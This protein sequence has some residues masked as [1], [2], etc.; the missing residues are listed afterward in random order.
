[1]CGSRNASR[2]ID[3]KSWRLICHPECCMGYAK[4][5][6]CPMDRYCRLH[7]T[8]GAWRVEQACT[9]QF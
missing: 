5:G 8:W 3:A 2:S 9:G 1:M 6:G 4:T 7:L